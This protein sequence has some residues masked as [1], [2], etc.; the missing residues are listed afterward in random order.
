LIDQGLGIVFS[1]WLEHE[2]RRARSRPRPVRAAV[3]EI[4]TSVADEKNRSRC[5]ADEVL[6]HVQQ[7]RLGPMDVIHDCDQRA[8][9]SQL[10]EENADG[11]EDLLARCRSLDEPERS[12]ET[13]DGQQPLVFSGE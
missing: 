12:R 6:E 7:R 13:L 3:E 4:R 10:F 2:G 11:P 5:E 9:T 8:L 1:E